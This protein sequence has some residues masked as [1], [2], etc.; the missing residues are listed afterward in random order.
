MYTPGG[1]NVQIL[2]TFYVFRQLFSFFRDRGKA[3]ISITF[4]ILYNLLPQEV[5]LR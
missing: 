1:H 3:L 4:I 2:A 5:N